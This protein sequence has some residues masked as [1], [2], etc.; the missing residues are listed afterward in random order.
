MGQAHFAQLP[1]IAPDLETAGHARFQ[2]HGA[3]L[4]VGGKAVGQ[5]RALDARQQGPHAGIIAADHV[6]AVERNLVHELDKGV[7][8]GLPGPVVVQMVFV[9][10]G[11]HVDDGEQT[12]EGA[13]G[14]VGFGDEV[15]AAA[16]MGIGAVD[17]EAPPDD[18][19]GVQTGR[20]EDGGRQGRG[21]G[22]AVG[23]GNGHALTQAHQFGQHLGTGDD[24][25]VAAA[26]FHHFGVVLGNGRGLDQHLHV[27]HVLGRMAHG[28]AG[29]KTAQMF[30]HGRIAHVR[31][32][33]V[34]AQV[35]QDFRDAAHAGAADAHHVNLP[36]LAVHMSLSIRKK[37]LS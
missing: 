1:V 13:V 4:V 37:M 11:D 31:A 3:Q 18:D 29:P 25:D 6:E 9:H 17:I 30:D 34:I 32:R 15:M 8:D 14:F 33:D 16:Q 20:I 5:H 10:V 12:E 2:Q 24:G 23:T 26:R 36:N 7:V 27:A 35:E 21:G 22:L 19:R 28:D